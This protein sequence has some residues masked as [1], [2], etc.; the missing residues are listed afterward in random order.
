MGELEPIKWDIAYQALWT[1]YSKGPAIIIV[2][3]LLLS[4]F[5]INFL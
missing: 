1:E 4:S 5:S 3:R 2:I